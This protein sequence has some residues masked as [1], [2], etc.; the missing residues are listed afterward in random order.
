MILG[1]NRPVR[2]FLLAAFS[3]LALALCC[4]GLE[5]GPHNLVGWFLLLMGLGYLVGGALY[6]LWYK[7]PTPTVH[8][9]VSDRSFFLILPGFLAVFFGPPLEFIYCPAILP[10]G[11]GIQAT[12]LL[13][14]I[15]AALLRLW[16]R[17]ALKEM[18]TG[19]IQV[20]VGHHLVQTGPYRWVRHPGYTG[21]VL[22]ALGISV[23]YA[24]FIGLVAILALML[25]ALA[26]RMQ[27][28]EKLLTQEFGDQYRAYSRGTKRLVPGV[29]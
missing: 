14:V 4:L 29:W 5:T 23:G 6:L 11:L 20:M 9:E 13:L 2:F 19:H 24:S 1:R 15:A 22:L 16:T 26:Y 12:G 8:E 17:Q 18:Y 7:P 21:F 25:P 27:V 3:L 28:E 10:R